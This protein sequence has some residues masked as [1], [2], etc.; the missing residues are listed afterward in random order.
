VTEAYL[1]Q[2]LQAESLAD[3]DILIKSLSPD[4]AFRLDSVVIRQGGRPC[5][6][7]LNGQPVEIVIRYT[8]IT[9]LRGLRVYFDVLDDNQDILIRTFHDDDSDAPSLVEPGEYKSI[10]TIPA[11]LLAPRMYT[12]RFYATIYNDRSCTPGGIGIPITVEASNGI[13]RAYPQDPIRSKL[14]PKISWITG[15]EGI[16][17]HA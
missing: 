3:V 9:H 17:N 14:Q 8:V 4:P 5:T 2:S 6:L 16:S 1:K 7:V 11:N 15:K 12:L 13:N 10:A